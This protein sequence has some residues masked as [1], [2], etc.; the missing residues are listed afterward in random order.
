VPESPARRAAIYQGAYTFEKT[1][2][3]RVKGMDECGDR[4]EFTACRR[5]L[6]ASLN[7]VAIV[8]EETSQLT[9]LQID[10]LADFIRR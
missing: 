2:Y 9:K 5:P 6:S 4:E 8:I 7:E 3:A 10:V 1:F